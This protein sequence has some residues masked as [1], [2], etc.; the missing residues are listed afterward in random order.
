MFP[1]EHFAF[2]HLQFTA[3][4][5]A[6]FWDHERWAQQSLRR[7]KK[8]EVHCLLR[9][10]PACTT[11]SQNPTQRCGKMQLKLVWW[12]FISWTKMDSTNILI[13]WY[14]L[15]KYICASKTIG[16]KWVQ[17]SAWCHARRITAHVSTHIIEFFF[18][19]NCNCSTICNPVAGCLH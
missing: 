5:T 4:V 18:V 10:R 14:M 15:Y 13:Y 1:L 17:H 3:D 9:D 19:A 16:L 7:W 11:K 12:N 2:H 8:D 6:A